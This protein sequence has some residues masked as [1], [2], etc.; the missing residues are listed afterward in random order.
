M[1]QGAG[2]APAWFVSETRLIMVSLDS[3]DYII[4]YLDGVIDSDDCPINH[5]A[6]SAMLFA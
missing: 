4:I 2:G 3:L 1:P 5:V 6:T